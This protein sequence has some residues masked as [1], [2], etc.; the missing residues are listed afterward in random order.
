[1][2]ECLRGFASPDVVVGLPSAPARPVQVLDA[3]DAPQPRRD[4]MAGR[5]M[6]VSVGRVRACEV[7]DAKFVLLVHNTIRGAAGGAILNA[8]LLVRT[9]WLKSR[10]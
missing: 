3:D 6:T 7:L 1:V 9:G 5:G 4:V 2:A 10:P 8:E